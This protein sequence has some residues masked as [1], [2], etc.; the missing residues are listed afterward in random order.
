MSLF[1]TTSLACPSCGKALSFETV[2][3]VNANRRPDLRKAILAGEFQRMD[4][5]KCGARFRLDPDFNYLDVA[6]SQWIVAAPV[7]GM[8]DWKRREEAACELFQ[9]A[10][11]KEAPEIAQDIGAKL[12][13]RITFGWP[14]LREKVLAAEYGLNDV[15]L[16]ACKA[17][18]MRGVKGLPV[19]AEFDLRLADLEGDQLIMAWL[20]NYDSAE[21]DAVKVPRSLHASVV[22]DPTGAWASLRQEFDGALFVD[23]NRMLVAQPKAAA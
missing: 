5:P 21:G 10:Y 20:R 8:A 6:R 14:A 13:P 11:G 3:S 9:R 17:A 2:Y 16:E 22:A 7:A 1:K 23:L 4:C 19:S 12:K 15:A 18:V